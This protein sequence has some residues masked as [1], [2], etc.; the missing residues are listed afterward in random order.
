MSTIN[1]D[2]RSGMNAAVAAELRTKR[3]AQRMTI[4]T[5]T[6]AS[7]Y[8]KM[9]LSTTRLSICVNCGRWDGSATS[10]RYTLPGATM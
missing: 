7:G 9:P 3:T 4:N 2:P 5:M 8:P 1:K 6:T 10:R